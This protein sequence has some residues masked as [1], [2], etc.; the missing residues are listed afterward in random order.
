MRKS[1]LAV[2]T[3]GLSLLVAGLLAPPASAAAKP[4]SVTVNITAV[5]DLVNNSDGL[6]IGDIKPGDVITGS[7]TYNPKTKDI[8]PSHEAGV[9][10]H[11]QPPY[12][13][14]INLGSFTART[15]PANVDFQMVIAN[16]QNGSDNY[17]VASFNN[18][19]GPGVD[20]IAWGLSDPTATA[21]SSTSLKKAGVP[22]MSSWQQADI[23]M[24]EVTGLDDRYLIR[25]HVTQAVK[26]S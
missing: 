26:V 11:N 15:D 12:G 22:V 3:V 23:N 20:I 18:V 21:L 7:Y 8:D 5:V 13:I 6:P 1:R 10:L 17:S 25:S 24:L 4:K 2:L 14:E 16:D 9:Y 19:G